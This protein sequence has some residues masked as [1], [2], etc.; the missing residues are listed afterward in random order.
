[1]AQ[2]T[3]TGQ[4]SNQYIEVKVEW[5]SEAIPEDNQSKVTANLY[6]RRTNT[7]YTTYGNGDFSITI[8]DSKKSYSGYVVIDTD[9]V[10]VMS[11]S[12]YVDHDADGQKRVMIYASGKM[13]ATTLQD[14][15]L[16]YP[17]D[18]DTIPRA[19]SV[20]ASNVTLG[21]KCK[22]TWTP[23]SSSFRFKIKFSLGGWSYTTGYISPATTSSYTYTGYTIPFDAA[24]Q[25]TGG[26][27]GTMTATLYTYMASVTVPIGSASDTFTVTV[28]TSA[29]TMPTVT[30]TLAPVSSLGSPFNSYYIQGYSR[31]KATLSATAKEGATITS[32]SMTVQGKTYGSPYQ[33]DLLTKS[34]SVAVTGRATDSRGISGNAVQ[35][36]TVVAYSKPQILPTTDESAIICARC[37]GNGNLTDSGTF[38]RIKARRSYSKVTAG[39]EQRNFCSIGYRYRTESST[40]FSPWYVLLNAQT[41]STD[42]VDTII[43]NHTFDST[44]AYVVQITVSD[45]IGNTDAAQFGIPTNDV[46]LHLSEGGK[47]IGLLRYAE[48]SDEKGIDV[49]APIHGGAVDNFTLG[50][51]LTATATAP[52]DLNDIKT[53]GNYYSPVAAN[54]MF[55]ANSPVTDS[56]FGLI[57]REIQHTDVIRQELFYSR[58][59]WQ[60]H[61]NGSVWSDW[62][63]YMMTGH[64]ETITADYVIETGVNTNSAGSWRF[65]KWRSGAVDMNGVFKVTP[66]MDGTIGTA[67]ARYSKQIQIPL[68]FEVENFQFTGTPA[69]NYFMFANANVVTD[70]LGD[71]KIAFRLLRFLDF[72]D[73]SV[74]VRIIASGRYKT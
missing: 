42:K 50:T 40:S 24:E 49:G 2:G 39:G 51:L 28:P 43:K 37:D 12:T 35:S 25:I 4:T 10:L 22:V 36:I 56:G 53:V 17:V 41:T 9:W 60:R 58:T 67:A 23:H 8:G 73:I 45:T 18:L 33:S 47:R 62:L 57:V 61:W 63:R 55:I 6:Y 44:T 52:L 20:S 1:M 26:K 7:G 46:T 30:M 3:I 5:S 70:D 65:R 29:S 74:D 27:T 16:S 11:Y 38:L 48:D 21:N 54:S 15:S 31:V 64:S 19:S 68:P 34:G 13:P 71:Q 66:E 14:T 32:Y 69:T 59:N 72:S